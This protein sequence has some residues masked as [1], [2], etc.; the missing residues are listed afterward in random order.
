MVGGAGVIKTGREFT[1]VAPASSPP[2]DGRL[3]KDV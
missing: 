3:I 2:E 1:S